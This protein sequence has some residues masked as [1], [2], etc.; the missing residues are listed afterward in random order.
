MKQFLLSILL[1]ALIVP[2]AFGADTFTPDQTGVTF[3]YQPDQP[4]PATQVVNLTSSSGAVPN[5]TVVSTTVTTKVWLQ[6]FAS[7]SQIFLATNNT[8]SSLPVGQYSGKVTVSADGFTDLVINVLLNVGTVSSGLTATP[9][10]FQ[11][12]YISG[13]TLP[14][15]QSMALTTT[16]TQVYNL[17]SSTVSGGAWLAV[18]PISGSTNTSL[19]VSV[20]P[21]TLA[22]GTYSGNINVTSQD[23]SS[24]TVPVTLVV[25]TTTGGSLSVSPSTLSFSYTTGGTVPGGQPVSVGSTVGAPTFTASSNSTWLSVS[26]TSGAMPATVSVTVNPVGLVTGPYTGVITF[27][28]S[29][30]TTN[31][32]TVSLNVNTTGSTSTTSILSFAPFVGT[33]QSQVFTVTFSDSVAASNIG[34]NY[35]LFNVNLSAPNA[36]YIEFNNQTKTIRLLNNA[37]SA[38]FGPSAIGVGGSLA[39]SQCTVFPSGATAITSGSAVS[40]TIPV[41]FS[42]AWSGGARNIYAQA[43]SVSGAIFDWLPY[44][45]WYPA[46][47]SVAQN[48]YRIYD[49]YTRSHHYTSDANEN[50]TLGA[51]GYT[52]EGIAGGVYSA[53]PAAP[54]GGVQAV[55]FYRMVVTNG[56][57]HF[58]TTDRNEYLTLIQNRAAYVSEAVAAFIMPAAPNANFIPFYRL[59]FNQSSPVLHFWTSDPFEYISLTSASNGKPPEWTGEGTVGFLLRPGTY[60]VGAA[61]RAIQNGQGQPTVVS[62]LN[63]AS[64]QD[65]A[66][67]PGQMVRI[68]G[69]NFGD[70]AAVSFDG[71]AARVLSVTGTEI[72]AIVPE[73]V[74]PDQS[75]QVQVISGGN[76]SNTQEVAVSR[77]RPALFASNPSGSGLAAAQNPDGSLITGENPA[78]KGSIITLYA[79]GLGLDT[80]S[81]KVAI[82]GLPTQ[83]V[84]VTATEEGLSQIRVVVPVEL[85]FDKQVP[86]SLQVGNEPSQMGVSLAIK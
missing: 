84:S 18:T 16:N 36:C 32:V 22:N 29:D 33:A 60:T 26:P 12:N 66:V 73:G 62:V 69:R 77:A 45:T 15:A 21:T 3:N 56:G 28:G 72:A 75:T 5:V 2:F 85:S 35:I 23:G 58:W 57:T 50:T 74:T 49:P 9:A 37:G 79:T 53:P 7:G 82:N 10:S 31:T 4:A 1:L 54:I 48:W 19:S 25:G 51:R 65:A 80:S 47:N 43:S 55:P 70:D 40:L 83:I 64:F 61:A 67:A 71:Q 44:G 42:N 27:T 34:T 41:T 30:F 63:G 52:T 6:A 86:V 11:F 24:I 76:L 81:L 46:V 39:N 78:E 13:G 20:N 38:W 68:F 14:P 59:V 8:L 17:T